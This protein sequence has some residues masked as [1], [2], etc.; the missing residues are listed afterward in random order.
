MGNVVVANKVEWVSLPTRDR[1]AASTSAAK[2]LPTSAPR[3]LRRNTKKAARPHP[4]FSHHQ[5]VSAFPDHCFG[6]VTVEMLTVR[7]PRSLLPCRMLRTTGCRTDW[8][9]GQPEFAARFELGVD[10]CV[11][12]RLILIPF[13]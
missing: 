10:G 4:S 5:P 6:G 8:R 3:I 11:S 2:P 9:S 1:R 12:G 13:C 7:P